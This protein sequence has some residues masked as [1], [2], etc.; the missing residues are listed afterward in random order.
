METPLQTLM[1]RQKTLSAKKPFSSLLRGAAAECNESNIEAATP[2]ED[3]RTNFITR[4]SDK[5]NK[6]RHRTELEH[7][8]QRDGEEIRNS[9]HRIKG[10]KDKGWPDDMNGT[11]TS[12]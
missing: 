4:Y 5:R 8:I 10:I 9:L 7:C 2:W 11:A 3:I 6:F 1:L 12:C